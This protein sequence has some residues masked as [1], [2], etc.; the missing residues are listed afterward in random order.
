[1]NN[2]NIKYLLIFAA[3]LVWGLVI[4][5]IIN[6]LQ[7]NDNSQTIIHPNIAIADYNIKADSFFLF[8]DYPDPFIPETDT[9][10]QQIDAI[11]EQM[12]AATV[13]AQ[14]NQV[15]SDTPAKIDM[16]FI[17][18]EGMVANT[19]VRNKKAGFINLRGKDVMVKEGQKIEGVLIKKINKQSLVI[20]FQN[21]KIVLKNNPK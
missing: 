10:Q 12:K 11:D 20:V 4:R 19:D 6:G 14:R 16:S 17:H 13:D 1:M 2:K 15:N 5:S 9:L 8:A 7:N 18:Y 3:V 21:K